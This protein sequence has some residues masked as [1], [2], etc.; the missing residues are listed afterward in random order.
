M[1]S[2]STVSGI[3]IPGPIP[4]SN[5]RFYHGIRRVIGFSIL[6]ALLAIDVDGALSFAYAHRVY[7]GIVM[8][9][10]SLGGLDEGTVKQQVASFAK[11]YKITLKLG[12]QEVQVIPEEAGI[13]LDVEATT[14]KLVQQGKN[15]FFVLGV[16]QSR[17]STS[18]QPVLHID[19]P[20]LAAFSQKIAAQYSVVPKDATMTIENGKLIVKNEENGKEVS[21]DEVGTQIEQALTNPYFRASVEPKPALAKIDQALLQPAIAKAQIILNAPVTLS[22]KDKHYTPDQVTKAEWM[23]IKNGGVEMNQEKLKAYIQTVVQEINQPK[24]DRVITSK[25]GNVITDVAGTAG[26]AV[27][28][29]K[30]IEQVNG[31]VNSKEAKEITIPTVSIEPATIHK[32]TTT[33]K[34]S[35]TVSVSSKVAYK[36][37]IRL[38]N[39]DDSEYEAFAAKL[40]S[41]YANPKGWS[42]D[43]KISFS[44]VETNCNYTAW[45]AAADQLSSFSPGCGADYSCRAGNNVI[46]NYDRWR[47]ATPAWTGSLDDYRMMVINHETGHWLSFGHA[48]CPGPNQVAP[49]MQ[50][51]SISL[52]GC[53]ANPFPIA[54]ER[55]RIANARG[56]TLGIF[57]LGFTRPTSIYSFIDSE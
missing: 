21:A 36:Y 26:I 16:Y 11:D 56:I 45:L 5:Y 31:A 13:T 10:Q 29:V 1:Y 35:P 34:K 50:Q 12:E 51:Q 41:V 23:I 3:L 32:N 40:S 39:V 42:L 43:G 17:N 47:Y 9:G 15:T 6:L 27:D 46:I 48:F 14:E 49:V 33:Y 24:K 7:P 55:Q 25:D 52:Q 18:L 28:E 53:E 37:C 2:T 20:T 8:A 19:K 38:K 44:K 22:Y 54:S 4:S 57:P 30:L